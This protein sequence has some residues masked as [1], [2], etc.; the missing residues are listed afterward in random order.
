M[1]TQRFPATREAFILRIPTGLPLEMDKF[2]RD[3]VNIL[4]RMQAD[5]DTI[6]GR[7]GLPKHFNVL[8]MNGN[9]I[10]NVGNL[11]SNGNVTI[12]GTLAVTGALTATLITGTTINASSAYQVAGTQVVTTQQ[13]AV[14]DATGAGDVVARLNDLLARVRTHGLIAP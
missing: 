14:A 9:A 4:E 6:I 3:I 10:T 5:L 11:A 7:R 12:A 2:V 1:A 8:D 13:A